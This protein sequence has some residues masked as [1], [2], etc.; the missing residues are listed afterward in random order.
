MTPKR[1][2]LFLFILGLGGGLGLIFLERLNPIPW[3]DI[4]A[5]F[6]GGLLVG[7]GCVI[8]NWYLERRSLDDSS[9][10][11]NGILFSLSAL[12]FVLSHILRLGW[13][14]PMAMGGFYAVLAL[15]CVGWEQH[16]RRALMW[17]DLRWPANW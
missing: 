17:R 11:P 1:F 8:A 14:G 12:G 15:A 7:L 4:A 16:S 5:W 10:R 2:A 3:T 13:H 9:C 6:T